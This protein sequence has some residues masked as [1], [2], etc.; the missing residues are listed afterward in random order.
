MVRWVVLMAVVCVLHTLPVGAADPRYTF[1]T[2]DLPAVGAGPGR[3]FNLR[4]IANDD[5]LAGDDNASQGL[6]ARVD[7][8][9]TVLPVTCPSTVF[10]RAPQSDRQGPEVVMMNNA[11]TVVGSDEHVSRALWGLL[12]T[13]DG[14]C[15]FLQVPGAAGTIYTTIDD[16]EVRAGHYFNL[17]SAA[18][19]GLLRFHAFV[20]DAA[21]T[22]T[23][24]VA[25]E[26]HSIVFITGRNI[27]GDMVGYLYLAI[28]PDNSYTYQAY[29][30]HDGV[31]TYLDGPAGE[32]LWCLGLNNV[33]QA[34]CVVGV[35]GVTQGP[36][37]LYDHITGTYSVI[38]HPTLLTSAMV[39]TDL[40]DLGTI[41]GAYTETSDTGPGFPLVT[42]HQFLATPVAPP[43]NPPPPGDPPRHRRH[44]RMRH[45]VAER[46][47]DVLKH[48][49]DA[50]DARHA[51][52]VT[53]RCATP[54]RPVLDDDGT[55]VLTNGVQVLGRRGR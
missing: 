7:P 21:G 33:Q 38:P 22:V 37:L 26:P 39:P 6:G 10:P 34:V 9:L 15:R 54:W 55:V 1:E 32:D 24:V 13:L 14:T 48:A 19:P 49:K 5:W 35:D 51:P 43:A 50:R 52:P 25:P 30:Y 8:A 46:L 27:L 16:N 20:E 23:A 45:H 28:Q 40:N 29:Y 11:K 44:P 2:L 18:E 4:A 3:L 42:P 36:A 41:T 47:R 12:Q 53:P 31:F 17:P